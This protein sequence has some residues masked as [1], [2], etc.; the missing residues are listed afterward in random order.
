MAMARASLLPSSSLLFPFHLALHQPYRV[1]KLGFL[2]HPPSRLEIANSPSSS[3]DP[4]LCS[5]R[6]FFG[7]TRGNGS[8]NFYHPAHVMKFSF[9]ALEDDMDS[10]VLIFL[11]DRDSNIELTIVHL[12]FGDHL[13]TLIELL[14][15]LGRLGWDVIKGTVTS[16]EASS[17]QTKVLIAQPNHI[18]QQLQGHKVEDHDV[19]EET[20]WFIYNSLLQYHP[21]FIHIMEELDLGEDV[22]VEYPRK[23]LGA[24]VS[25][26]VKDDGPRRSLLTIETAVHPGLLLGII[27][28]LF[29]LNV[30][31]ELAEFY[32]YESVAKGKFHVSCNGAALDD[33]QTLDLIHSLE[34]L[35]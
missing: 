35:L 19:L 17:L 29:R 1:P 22:T 9:K 20:G 4:M 25:V 11:M 3:M 28:N 13:W 2:P 33:F 12:S 5:R 16:E 24:D 23:K 32:N 10:D 8:R 7:T 6:G 15:A 30:N 26:H 34:S 21:E 31:V 18:N 27:K 14:E